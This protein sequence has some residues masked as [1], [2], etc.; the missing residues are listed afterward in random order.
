MAFH[1]LEFMLSVRL[2]LDFPMFYGEWLVGILKNY[3]PNNDNHFELI[4][5]IVSAYIANNAIPAVK[6]TQIMANVHSAIVLPSMDESDLNEVSPRQRE[7]K[8]AVPIKKSV[9]HDHLVCLE[10]GKKY[11]SLKR[12]FAAHHGMTPDEYR[13]K[14]NLPA[15]YAMTA[16]GYSE[17]RSTPAKES[18]LGRTLT[19]KIGAAAGPSGQK[20]IPKVR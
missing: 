3:Q 7:L 17:T 4:G 16:P 10:D 5:K 12:H 13:S 11:K 9:Q 18:G 19:K 8:P 2:A 6:L 15:T 1:Q 20:R 14:W